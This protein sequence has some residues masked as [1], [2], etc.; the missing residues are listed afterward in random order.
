MTSN[1]SRNVTARI[2]DYLVITFIDTFV[3]ILETFRPG[4]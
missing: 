3:R 1:S 2:R 4:G